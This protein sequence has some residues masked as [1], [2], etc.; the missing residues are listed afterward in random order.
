MNITVWCMTLITKVV[1]NGQGRC[2]IKDF[3]ISVVVNVA[4]Q[5]VVVAV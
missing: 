3:A 5:I 4:L 2:C 1:N